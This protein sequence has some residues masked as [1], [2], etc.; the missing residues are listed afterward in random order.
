MAFCDNFKIDNANVAF[1]NHM[2]L[3]TNNRKLIILFYISDQL[4]ALTPFPG[5]KYPFMKYSPSDII[6]RN[7]PFFVSVIS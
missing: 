2:A 3:N 1:E 7:F 5:L 4:P 6:Q